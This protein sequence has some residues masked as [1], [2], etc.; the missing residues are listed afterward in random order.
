MGKKKKQKRMPKGHR[1]IEGEAY[2]KD[3]RSPE[4]KK[5]AKGRAKSLRGQGMKARVVPAKGGYNTYTTQSAKRRR[6]NR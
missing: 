2:W 3:N 4:S 1:N 5:K 6:R